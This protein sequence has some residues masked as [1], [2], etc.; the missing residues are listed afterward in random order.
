MSGEYYGAMRR[1]RLITAAAELTSTLVL[2]CSLS[3]ETFSME[4]M[5]GLQPHEVTVEPATYQGRKA[6]RVM[7][8]PS[9]AARSASGGRG[10]HVS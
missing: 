5:D 6:V 8:L 10:H 9:A 3:G 7:P 4:S 2:T 1:N